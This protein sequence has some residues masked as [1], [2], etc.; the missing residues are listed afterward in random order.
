[1]SL[2]RKV[3]AAAQ[4]VGQSAGVAMNETPFMAR[5]AGVAVLKSSGDRVVKL[6]ES[7]DGVT[8]TDVSGVTLSSGTDRFS[9]A[10]LADFYRIDVSG[11]TA[12]TGDCEIEA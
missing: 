5:H 6:Q 4:A 1:M 11:G 3:I 2:Q 12:G 8:Y 9:L 7:S 10:S